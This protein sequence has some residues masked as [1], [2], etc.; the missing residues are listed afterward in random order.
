METYQPK[1][2]GSEPE[3]F[4][5]RVRSAAWALTA[6]GTPIRYLGSI[7]VP[8][9]ETCF[10]LYRAQSERV[11]EEVS[12]RAGFESPRIVPALL[13]QDEEIPGPSVQRRG[14]FDWRKGSR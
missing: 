6:E 4:V 8:E 13:F 2:R 14:K 7:L 9:E 11:V 12:R 10:H 1:R 3:E 5:R